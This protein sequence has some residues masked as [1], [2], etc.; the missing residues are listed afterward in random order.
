MKDIK[1]LRKELT[2]VFAD[3]KKGKIDPKIVKELNNTA[4][5][6]NQTVN[7]QLKYA[8]LTKS[9]T[10]IGFLECEDGE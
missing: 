8:E 3:C 7:L 5:K 6:I 1:S 2:K 9:K 4:G 10:K